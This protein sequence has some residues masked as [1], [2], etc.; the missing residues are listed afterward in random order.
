MTTS[1][2][3]SL[4]ALAAASTLAFAVLSMPAEAGLRQKN[5]IQFN[6][7]VLQGVSLQGITLQGISLQGISLQGVQFNGMKINGTQFTGA[8][9]AQYL[10]VTL[11]SG[12]TVSLR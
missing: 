3:F 5:G 10:A 9:A 4:S 8:K 2:S 1:K 6:G 12:E 7:P 11:P